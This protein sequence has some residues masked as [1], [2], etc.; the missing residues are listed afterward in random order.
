M[1]KIAVKLTELLIRKHIIESS[2]KDIYQYGFL[3]S[4]EIGAAFITSML[5]CLSMGM[6]KE[7]LIFFAFFIPLRSYLGGVHLKK[8][9][10]C[11]LASCVIL[12]LMLLAV[13]YIV[14][15]PGITGVTI[16]LGVIG[17]ITA[18]V[19][20]YR[21]YKNKIYFLII[22]IVLSLLSGLSLFF[23][24]RGLFSM[25]FLLCCTVL[26]VLGSK[27]MERIAQSVRMTEDEM[28]G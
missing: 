5:I 4:L 20:D 23:Y 25:M 19:I 8:Y 7:G 14:P 3:C 1:E 12:L 27:M 11:Y 15:E 13:K 10:Q 6:L 9:W 28:P 2:M 18:A 16:M 22:C 26:L 21:G 24:A 17:T